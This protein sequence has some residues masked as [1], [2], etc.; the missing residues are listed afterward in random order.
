MINIKN[1]TFFVVFLLLL[2]ILYMCFKPVIWKS[3][4]KP[5]EPG[6]KIVA[7]GDSL[8]Y[9]YKMNRD[10]TYPSFLE[11]SLNN[12][13]HVLNYG[14][15]G[16]TTVDGLERFQEMLDNERPDLII[17]GLG[18]NDILK[19]V[20]E[21]NTIKNLTKMI[22]MARQS[23]SDIV[24]LPNPE[25]SMF[26]FIWGFSDYQVFDEVSEK[27]KTP[28]LS[29]VYSKWLSKSNYKIDAIHLTRDGYYE[30]AQDIRKQLQKNKVI[31]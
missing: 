25:P 31:E 7:F 2:L 5:L 11:S 29:N 15:N 21:K 23:G 27:T 20:G 6:A 13:Y 28:V 1:K 16:N 4:L 19:K 17:L 12:K 26:G 8:T 14:I 18:G 9:G 30:V 24:L 3:T 10:E 22:D